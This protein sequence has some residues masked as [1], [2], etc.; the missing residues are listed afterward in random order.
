MQ[1]YW[2]HAISCCKDPVTGECKNPDD[3]SKTFSWSALEDFEPIDLRD[4]VKDGEATTTDDLLKK[5]EEEIVK[6]IQSRFHR[7]DHIH[8][9]LQQ[10]YSH[11]RKA[12]LFDSL[13]S[14]IN[15]PEALE[16]EARAIFDSIDL[17]KDSI[18][19]KDEFLKA[20]PQLDEKTAD[21]LFEEMDTDKDG[22]ISFDELWT[23]IKSLAAA[24][25]REQDLKR[26]RSNKSSK[27]VERGSSSPGDS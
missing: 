8:S 17:N 5:A 4:A 18:I 3:T 10:S 14:D 24:N 26:S 19:S 16:K 2:K 12:V 25:A 1:G 13:K 20:F 15:N 7:G 11:R 22:A 9:I 6:R 27:E 21:L 23:M